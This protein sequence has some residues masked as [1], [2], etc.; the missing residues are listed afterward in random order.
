MRGPFCG[1]ALN[2]GFQ[3]LQ[4]LT[5]DAT[6][7]L[8]CPP[9]PLPIIGPVR[10]TTQAMEWTRG[11]TRMEIFADAVFAI[12]FTLPMVELKLPGAALTSNGICLSYGP[13]IWGMRSDAGDRHLLGPPSLLR[14]N[15]SK[16]RAPFPFGSA[17][18]PRGSWIYRVPHARLCR[19]HP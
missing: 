7:C 17:S 13:P 19:K 5:S 15:L 14:C 6:K 3:P 1:W 8:K 11:T 18:F 10:T 12:A 4:T 2:V 16:D 9:K